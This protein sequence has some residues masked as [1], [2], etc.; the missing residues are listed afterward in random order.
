MKN[1]TQIWIG[2]MYFKL[3]VLVTANNTSYYLLYKSKKLE[4][5]LGNAT[6]LA[7]SRFSSLL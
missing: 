3:N 4:T 7:K 1:P 5:F 2:K 6:S